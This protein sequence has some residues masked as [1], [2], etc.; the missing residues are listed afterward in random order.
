MEL[1]SGTLLWLLIGAAT[2]SVV[3]TVWLWPRLVRQ[4]AVR[5]A[6]RLGLIVVSQALVLSAALAY[7][8][9]SFGFFSS[10]ATLLGNA[11][12]QQV[13]TSTAAPAGGRP[14]LITGFSVGTAFSG[15]SVPPAAT[16]RLAAGTVPISLGSRGQ[17]S[18]ASAATSGA[19]ARVTIRGEYTGI[20]AV[21][22]YVYLPPQ[23]FQP[24]YADARFPVILTFT[25][26]PND[27]LNLMRLLRLPVIAARL[28]AAG[29]VRPAIYVMVNPSVALPQDTECTNVPAG[30]QVATFFGRDVPLA[31]QR[32]FRVQAGRAGWAT[33]G[34]STGA[35]CA[36][37]MAML[38]PDQFSAAVGLSGYYVALKDRTTGDIYGGSLAYRNEN[39]LDWRLQHLPAPPVSVLVASSANGELNLPGTRAFLKL[40]RPPMRGYALILR[41][42]GHNY[43]TWRR[44]LPQ[45]LE[46]LSSRLT[47]VQARPETRPGPVV[48]RSWTADPEALAVTP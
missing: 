16:A 11:V 1:T 44:E 26:Y 32:T 13:L 14:I 21:N 4:H 12:P 7:V 20:T 22:D 31:V 38:Y 39:N 48:R 42:G 35:Y 23:Y 6:A 9:D 24:A 34:Y 36:A 40:I 5:V 45:S 18:K 41:Q 47:P 27:P 29:R 15:G 8:N 30:L 2:G 28:A 3:A 19:V 43:Y 25:G 10:W 33:L 46:W 37:K 17:P